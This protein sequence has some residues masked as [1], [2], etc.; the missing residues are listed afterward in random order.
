M[1]VYIL[2]SCAVIAVLRNETGAE[3][4]RAVMRS[5]DPVLLAAI[6]MLEICYDQMRFCGDDEAGRGV[7]LVF[8]GDGRGLGEEP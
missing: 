7:V 1:T 8:L 2:D 3:R 5:G 4:V 6:N